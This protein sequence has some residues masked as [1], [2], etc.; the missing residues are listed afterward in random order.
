[1]LN[2][3]AAKQMSLLQISGFFALWRRKHK[4]GN[5]EAGDAGLSV[6]PRKGSTPHTLKRLR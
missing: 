5:S 2:A 3:F 1:M 6:A 4:I